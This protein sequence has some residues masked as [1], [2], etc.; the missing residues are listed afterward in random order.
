MRKLDKNID[1]IIPKQQLNLYGYDTHFE[2]FIRLYQ[3][4]RYKLWPNYIARDSE[5]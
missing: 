3:N 1:V 5:V 4:K 2:T